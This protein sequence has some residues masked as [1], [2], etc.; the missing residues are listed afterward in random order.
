MQSMLQIGV[1]EFEPVC[2][3]SPGV[4]VSRIDYGAASRFVISKSGGFGGPEL[5]IH[6]AERLE[7]RS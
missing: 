4:V 3:L 7:N 6:L 5:L 2:E 1:S